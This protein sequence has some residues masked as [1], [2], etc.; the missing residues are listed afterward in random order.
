MSKHKGKK[1]REN[2]ESLYLFLSLPPMAA[3]KSGKPMCIRR[4]NFLISL[5]ACLRGDS[6]LL[7]TPVNISFHYTVHEYARG[8]RNKLHTK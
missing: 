6:L 4:P 2:K 5:D 3:E 1:K 7:T 8:W